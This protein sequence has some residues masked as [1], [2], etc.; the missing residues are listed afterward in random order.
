MKKFFMTCPFQPAGSLRPQHYEAV[1]NARLRYEKETRFPLIQLLNSYAEDDEQVE[2]YVVKADYKNAEENY[3]LFEEELEA[4]KAKKHLDCTPVPITVPYDDSL[5]TQLKIFEEL[6]TRTAD[7]DT[8]Y[9]C[10]TYGSK[11]MPM[12]MMMAF[13]YAHRFHKDVTIDCMVYGKFD[14]DSHKAQIYDITSLLYMD[15]I[16]RLMAEQKVSDPM[17]HIRKLLDL[18]SR[19]EAQP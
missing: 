18:D 8:L 5:D 2:V 15:E 3:K 12:V 6:I 10:I 1:D 11:P 13:N 7:S 17:R 14:H 16:T 4:L 9:G 19:E